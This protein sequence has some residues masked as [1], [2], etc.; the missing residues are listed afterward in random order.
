MCKKAI[1]TRNGDAA[2]V[3]HLA[4]VLASKLDKK[5]NERNGKSSRRDLSRVT[6]HRKGGEICNPTYRWCLF[7]WSSI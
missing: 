2:S 4:S 5:E 6:F 1:T 3:F 7:K